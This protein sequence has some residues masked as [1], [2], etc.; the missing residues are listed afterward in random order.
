MLEILPA[1]MCIFFLLQGEIQWEECS[2]KITWVITGLHSKFDPE[3]LDLENC[4]LLFDPHG[5]P[6]FKKSASRVY[7]SHF[8][9]MFAF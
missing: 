3:E 7:L 9:F 1:H 6:T 2:Y 8:C 5:E 4:K